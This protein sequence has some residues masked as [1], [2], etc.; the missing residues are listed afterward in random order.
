MC[1]GECRTSSFT[2][3]VDK[4]LIKMSSVLGA[5]RCPGGDNPEVTRTWQQLALAGAHDKRANPDLT[6]RNGIEDSI[7]ATAG[8]FVR[9]PVRNASNS[10]MSRTATL[11]R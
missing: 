3:R 7:D 10:L 2:C 4:I 5:W 11:S 1:W 8:I 6:R 9:R